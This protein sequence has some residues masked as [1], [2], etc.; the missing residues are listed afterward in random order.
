MNKDFNIPA[1]LSKDGY[2][3]AKVVRKVLGE[4][5]SGGGCRAFYTPEE[6][7]QRGEK[8][9]LGAEL[10][11]VHDGGDAAPYFNLDYMMYELHD[12]MQNELEK[13]GLY[14]EACTSWYTAVYPVV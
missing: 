14:A 8:Y 6:W 10:I 2:E 3:A 5:A 1:G 12:K 7:R 13:V 4:Q 9:G 11:V